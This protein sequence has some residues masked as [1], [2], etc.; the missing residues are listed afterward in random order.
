MQVVCHQCPHHSLALLRPVLVIPVY[1]DA[2][3]IVM[4]AIRGR[5][6][7]FMGK[8]QHGDGKVSCM[9]ASTSYNIIM[10]RRSQQC[11]VN[12]LPVAELTHSP[13]AHW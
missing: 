10:C 5:L 2:T 4:G 1:L 8:P 7:K 6:R 11:L 9:I 13:T 3:T 12:T